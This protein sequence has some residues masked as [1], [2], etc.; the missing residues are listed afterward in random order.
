MVDFTIAIPTYNGASR[1]PAL[2]DRL[3]SQTQPEGKQWEVVVVDNNSTDATAEVVRQYQDHWPEGV[4]LRYCFESEQGLAYA[5]Q[6]AIDVARA[7]LVGF[8]DD[9]NLPAADWVAEAICFAAEHPRAGV[10][11]GQIHGDYETPPPSGFKR[12]QSF[13]AIRE[14]GSNPHQYD[15]RRLNLPPGAAMV[16]RKSVWQAHVPLRLTLVGRVNGSSLSGED[17]ETLLHFY[18]AGWEIWYCPTMHTY[19]QI[20]RHRL[21]R[22]YLLSLVKGAGLCVCQ[23]RLMYVPL[24]QK[25]L[26]VA[27]I[28]AG[29]LKRSL[30]HWLKYR[31]QLA[32]DLVAECEL[33]YFWSCVV[34]PVFYLRTSLSRY[35]GRSPQIHSSSSA[36]PPSATSSPVALSK[37]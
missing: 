21:E 24:W 14:R 36:M 12:I 17:Y 31:R 11:G 20:P 4:S 22:P 6:K 28:V 37:D 23:L 34:S 26:V 1:L 5:R 13:L 16:V 9:D 29:S 33:A 2:L 30:T 18:H 8:L 7:E 25:P 27:Q 15:P 19:H 32:S 3:R 35:W 10:Y